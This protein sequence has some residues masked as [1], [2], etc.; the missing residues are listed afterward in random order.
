MRHYINLFSVSSN[1][2][3]QIG[4]VLKRILLGSW[5]WSFKFENPYLMM[6]FLLASHAFAYRKELCEIK[7][8]SPIMASS[9]SARC[10]STWI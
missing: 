9:R 5:F 7:I 6:A 2:I 3:A 10:P 1:T 4:E 8:K